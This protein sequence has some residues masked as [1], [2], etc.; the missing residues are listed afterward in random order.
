MTPIGMP[1]RKLKLAIDFFERVITGFWPVIVATSA[2]AVSRARA[3][4][5]ASPRPMFSTIFC[6]L[7]ICIGFV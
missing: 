5:R 3:F 4:S 7:G 2:E 1:S 6:S